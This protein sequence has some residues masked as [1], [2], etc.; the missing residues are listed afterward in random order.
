[1]VRDLVPD[2]SNFYEQH[3]SIQPYL[4]VDDHAAL[5]SSKTEQLQTREDRKKLDG[6]YEC[7]LCACCSTSCPSY[8]WAGNENKYLGPAILLQAYR[9]IA[10]SRDQ[11]TNQRLRCALSIPTP[12][13]LHSLRNGHHLK[14]GC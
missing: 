9:W 6:L 13:P 4:Q 2:L 3:K 14:S 5:G 11:H 1:V 10:D 12:I 7:I 8:W